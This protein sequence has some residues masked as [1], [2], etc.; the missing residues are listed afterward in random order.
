MQLYVCGTVVRRVVLKDKRCEKKQTGLKQ[1]E[2]KHEDIPD[3]SLHSRLCSLAWLAS[4]TAGSTSQQSHLKK[5]AN[6]RCIPSKNKGVGEVDSEVRATI[7]T[8]G[9]LHQKRTN[10][11]AFSSTRRTP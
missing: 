9:L 2:H 1:Q 6:F 7:E 5:I 8:K 11:T 10:P 4:S 3:P